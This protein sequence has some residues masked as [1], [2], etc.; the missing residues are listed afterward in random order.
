MLDPDGCLARSAMRTQ[1]STEETGAVRT[2]WLQATDQRRWQLA[3][4]KKIARHLDD[5]P[6]NGCHRNRAGARRG[7]GSLHRGRQK[8]SQPSLRAKRSNPS[9]REKKEWI[10]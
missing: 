5:Q 8:N 10:A 9:H 7:E 3:L 4:P 6:A 1:P 2:Q